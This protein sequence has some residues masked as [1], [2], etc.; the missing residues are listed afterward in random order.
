M[1]TVF[2]AKTFFSALFTFLVVAACSDNEDTPTMDVSSSSVTILATGGE[3][4]IEITTNQSEW[5]ASHPTTDTWCTLKKEGNTLIISA[6]ANEAVTPRS[7]KVIVT[8]G[9]GTNATTQEIAVQQNAATPYLEIEGTTPVAIN[10]AG[11]AVELIIKT[12]NEDWNATLPETDTW[13][14]LTK[15]GNKLTIT[16]TAYT[17]N[18][19]RNTTITLTSGADATL[20]TKPLSVTQK[21]EAPSYSIAIPNALLFSDGCVKKVMYNGSKI[22]EICKEYI[23]TGSTDRSMVI[24][25]PVVDGKVDLTKGFAALTAGKIVWNLDN[26]TCTYTAGSE[27]TTVKT[28]YL[29]NGE[30]STT[31]AVS[32][33]LATTVEDEFLVDNRPGDAK[34][35]YRIVKIGTQYWM[36][37]NLQAQR[38]INGDEIPYIAAINA[39]GVAEWNANKTG[40]HRYAQGDVT[41]LA[42]Y[43]AIY[44]GYAMDNAAGLVPE[45]WIIPSNDDWNKMLNYVDDKPLANAGGKLKATNYWATSGGGT[46]ITGFEARG[47]GQFVPVVDQGDV[48]GNTQ[49]CF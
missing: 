19:E 41:Y 13:C 22:A 4:S 36:A 29:T 25:Y 42:T 2:N 47:V 10:A 15:D 3:T 27:S 33:P 28:A 23:R 46:N 44:N 24:V 9:T 48:G 8:A 17:V 40:A 38:Y 43:G 12:N 18:E 21:G 45:G 14:T 26:N 16:A 20:V 6:P 32:S 39:T 31:T 49:A 37:E 5:N 7:T 1:K 35:N 30:I 34:K 11:D